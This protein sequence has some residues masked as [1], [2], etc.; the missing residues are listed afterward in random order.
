MIKKLFISAIVLLSI[1]V[2]TSSWGRSIITGQVV[3]AETG[4][5]I[6]NA[7]VYIYWSKTGSGPPGLAGDVE[8]EVAET[9]TDAEG[10]FNI[11]KYSTFFKDYEMTIYK[12]GY[13]CWNSID[14][15][16]TYEKRKDFKLKNG[17]VIKLEYFKEKYSKLKHARFT[18]TSSIGRNM[19]GKFDGAIKEE[20]KI[21]KDFYRSQRDKRRK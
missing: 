7:A 8:V 12:K 10:F 17:M 14:I 6:E 3:D 19:P 2:S 13:V 1:F 11:P 20:E 15:F 21:E 9:L 18:T 4:K 5:P 16:P